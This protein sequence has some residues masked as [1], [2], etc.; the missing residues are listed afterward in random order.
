MKSKF[1]NLTIAAALL[2]AAIL[3][4]CT[5]EETNDVNAT[6]SLLLKVLPATTR[7][8]A[9]PVASGVK[10]TLQAPGWVFF[11][12]SSGLITKKLEIK[13]NGA[14]PYDATNFPDQVTVS[15]LS[16][17]EIQNVPASSS[18][19]HVFATLPS[20][21]TLPAVTAGVTNISACLGAPLTVA[22]VASGGN[23]SSIPL[24]GNGSIVANGG[25]A[26]EFEAGVE[27]APVAGRVELAKI[28]ADAG[29]ISE[30]KVSGV[31]V[32]YYYGSVDFTLA[33]AGV[34]PLVNNGQ[35]KASYAAGQA[36]YTTAGLL[37]DEPGTTSAASAVDFAPNVIAYNLL[38][39]AAT[40]Y[41][42][43]L[44][45]KITGVKT[46]DVAL[47]ATYDNGGDPWFITVTNVVT[48]AAP[49]V[50]LDFESCKIYKIGNLKFGLGD[51]SVVPEPSNK[52]VTV[53]AS[54]QEWVAVPVEPVLN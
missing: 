38:P 13:A 29:E 7:A 47:Q 44:V 3:A 54:V 24:S 23:V 26:D 19:V 14:D 6:R 12:S 36:G 34:D 11:V 21:G 31:Y 10:S 39:R 28:S 17:V 1:L 41:F 46:K 32:N 8:T 50:N 25:D 9:P 2:L 18:R 52:R 48:S 45:L 42:P 53:T 43:H 16:G 33:P 49:A 20:T 27:I 4:G 5:R 35:V 22:N 40:G 15:D 30:F 37:H 51:L